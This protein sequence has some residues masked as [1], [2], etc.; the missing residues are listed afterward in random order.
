MSAHLLQ[1]VWFS[2]SCCLKM[3]HLLEMWGSGL[4]EGTQAFL[5]NIFLKNLL[6]L[7]QNH[8]SV[9]GLAQWPQPSQQHLMWSWPDE[10]NR[11]I[12]AFKRLV[13]VCALFLSQN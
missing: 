12:F 10:L 2:L 13:C 8:A 7:A 4:Y 6:P 9:T 11:P 1:T 5:E 3:K